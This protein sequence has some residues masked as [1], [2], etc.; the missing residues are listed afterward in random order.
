MTLQLLH[1]VFPYIG[2]KFDFLFYQCGKV[3]KNTF[4]VIYCRSACLHPY[5]SFKFEQMLCWNFLTV[6]GGQEPSK[7]RFVVRARICRRLQ[8]TGIDSAD[9]CSMAGRYD[10]QGV[11]TGPPGQESIPGLLKRFTN[12]GAGPPGYIGWHNRFRGIDSWAP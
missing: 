8:S 4:L 11:R 12:T 7:N 6:F 9:L 2:G 5:R 1:S 3:P 10:E